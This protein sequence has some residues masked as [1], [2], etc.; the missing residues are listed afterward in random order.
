M[1]L[2]F[3]DLV[4]V[5]NED[6]TA[7]A[8]KWATGISGR[9][10]GAQQINIVDL[11][12]RNHLDQHPNKVK[13]PPGMP[14]STQNLV[15]LLGDLFL[16]I[17]QVKMAVKI[18]HEN[19]ILDERPQSKKS[20][21]TMYNK[22]EA[23]EKIIAGVGKDIDDFTVDTTKEEKPKKL[24]QKEQQKKKKYHKKLKSLDK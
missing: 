19:P 23:C 1:D 22:L 8:D 9:M 12:R 24:S 3:S 18:A 2:K 16:Q 17:D 21:S 15:Q 14:H 4:D 5:I 7:M 13:A 11:L 10:A 6:S 20:L